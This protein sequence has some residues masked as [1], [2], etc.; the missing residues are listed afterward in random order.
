MCVP[1]GYGPPD[2]VMESHNLLR[3]FHCEVLFE[4][5]RWKRR[6]EEGVHILPL[7]PRKQTIEHARQEA[8]II[9]H[10]SFHGS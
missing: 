2:P 5:L 3:H 10:V 7:Q 9:A 8:T 6:T 1:A 4:N